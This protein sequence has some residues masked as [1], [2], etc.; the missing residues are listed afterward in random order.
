MQT[1]V[2]STKFLLF[3]SPNFLHFIFACML[4]TQ[5]YCNPIR[6][7][8]VQIMEGILFLLELANHLSVIQRK[9]DRKHIF[10]VIWWLFVRFDWYLPYFL[11]LKSYTPQQIFW[12]LIEYINFYTSVAKLSICWTFQG[13]NVLIYPKN[14]TWFIS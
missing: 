8:F 2:R 12:K 14:M 7:L 4:V 5:F 11:F 10:I 3:N 1:L 6:F 13:V 9:P